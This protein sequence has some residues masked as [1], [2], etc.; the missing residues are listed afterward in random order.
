[1]CA[2]TVVNRR[3][4]IAIL[5][6]TCVIDFSVLAAAGILPLVQLAAIAA[7]GM[8]IVLAVG[9]LLPGRRSAEEIELAMAARL[10]S[11]VC[12]DLAAA[13]LLLSNTSDA[14]S[15]GAAKSAIGRAEGSL[16]EAIRAE[17]LERQMSLRGTVRD[18]VIESA[19]PALR[20]AVRLQAHTNRKLTD[21]ERR[22][23]VELVSEATANARKHGRATEV[24]VEI[25][26][27]TSG[28]RA[29][30]WSDGDHVEVDDFRPGLGLSILDEICRRAGYRLQIE[31]PPIGGTLVRVAA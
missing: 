21:D 6:L 28:F 15:L 18:L 19:H 22:V 9:L 11:D 4:V 2:G 8:A 13:R 5:C 10:H 25:S 7:A 1:M 31:S 17:L 14:R 12:Q 24:E 16:R 20:D 23:V 3:S 29:S 30:V 26:A 27:L